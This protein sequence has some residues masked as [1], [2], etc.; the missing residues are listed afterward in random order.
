MFIDEVRV[1]L[2]AGD[3]GKGSSSLRREKFIPRGGP[4]GGDGGHG[5]NVVLLGDENVGDLREFHFNPQARA[6]NGQ[7]GMSSQKNGA[8]G[9]SVVLKVPCGTVVRNLADGSVCAEILH[10]GEEIVL[11]K[12]GNGGWGNMHFKSS[13]NRAPRQ[14]KEGLPG[15]SGEF[16]FEL[17]SIADVGLVGYP[18]AGKSTLTTLLTSATPKTAPYPFTT[19][20]ANVGV[21]EFPETYETLRLAD[22]PGLVEGAHANKGLGHRFLRHIERCSILLF[23]I[24]MQGTDGREPVEDFRVLLEELRLYDE[25]LLQ[26]PRLVVANK[27]D[28]PDASEKLKEFVEVYPAETVLPVSCLSEEGLDHLKT[29]LKRMVGDFSAEKHPA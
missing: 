29:T 21:L 17:K 15:A 1:K 9:A 6:E 19:L 25:N 18:N 12:G 27:M 22:I 4:D 13:V 7:N 3:G 20:H 14:F 10:H 26:K 11:L 16:I 28:E 8:R 5:G 24:D 2:K 23:L